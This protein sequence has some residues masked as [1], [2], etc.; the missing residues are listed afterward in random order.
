MSADSE[1][2]IKEAFQRAQKG[3]NNKAKL[4][5]SLNSRYNK[6]EDKTLFHEEFVHYLKYAMIVYKREP[7]V[8]NVIEFVVRFATSFQSPPK[9]EEEEEEKEEEE[10]EDDAEDDHPFLSFIFNF[11]LESHKANSHAVRFRVCQLINKLLGSMA[12]NA[13]IDDDLFDRIHQ[14]M[15]VRV[16]DKFPNVRIQAALAM[17]RL[18]QPKE[19]DCPTINAYMLI[20]DNDT[21]AEVRRAVLSCIAMSPRTLP[22]VLKRTRDIK[23][24]VRKLAYQVLADKVH[25]KA[26]TIAQRVGLLQQGLHDTS[27]A[28]REVVCSRMLPS[29]MLRLDGNVI[30]LL[31]R[32]DVENCAQTALDTLKAIFKGTPTEELL[33]N[34]VQL[35]NRKLIPVDSLSCENVLYWRALY[36]FIKAKGEDGDEILEQVL[37][38]AAIYADYLYGYLKTVPLLSEEQRAD[39]NQ[40]E[41]VMT[42]EFISQQ[43]IHLIGCLDT[44]E[45]GGR[46]RVFA[47]LQEMLALPQTPSSLVSLLTEKL[48]TLVPDDHRRIQTVAELISDL[49]EPINEASQPVD[50]NM[51][52][53]Q[54][55]QLAEVKVSILEAKQ[56]LEDCITTQDF[57]RAAELKDAITELENRRN[58]IIQEIAESNQP[59]DKEPRTEK[60]DPETLLRCLTMF[61][62]LLKQ[63]SLKTRIGPTI[64][65]LMS[66]LVLPSIANAHPAVRNMAVQCLGTCTLHSKELAKTHMVL[67]LQIAQLDEV[68]IRICALRAIIDQLLLFGFQLLSDP[69]ATQTVLPSQSPDRQGDGPV[70][71]KKGDVAED[72]AQSI[73]VMLS[74]FLDSE[75]SDLR[76]ETAEGLAKLMYNGRI[77]S[78]KMFSRLVLLWYNPVTE[79]DIRLR[80]CLGVFFQLYARESRVHQE[81]VEEGFLPTV[82]TLMNAPAT[83]PLAEVDINN[84]VELLVELTRPSALIK[85]S[86]NTEEVCVHDYLAVRMCGEM[87]KDP[88]APEVRLYAKTLSNLEL[89][90]DETVRKDLQV[91]LQQ[92]VQVVKDRVCLCALE[93]MIYQLVNSREQAELLSASA[94]QPLDVN[95]DELAADDPSKSAKKAKKGQRKV[96]TAKG[97]RKSSRRAESSE[98]SD[99]EN[100]P[101]SV[102]VVRPSRR[103]KTA[104]LEKT[105][106]DLNPLINQEANLS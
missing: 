84:V 18:Q 103:A 72:T 81:V 85:A 21:N 70:A 98:E 41:L 88:T 104:A 24:N 12:E 76:T 60:N 10:E 46:K 32:L 87:L 26:L 45:E 63:M 29:W 97:G 15:L 27:E 48:L 91:L 66:S 101:E 53:R 54:Q 16:T 67:L 31:H 79:D 42:K 30:E 94:L 25:I 83:S 75:V 102:P 34:R 77:S 49:R 38:D 37:P 99:G 22:K 39:F 47:V 82:R 9:T 50:E 93:K 20:L 95:A 69:A 62:E 96:C 80:H 1:I 35:D 13:Q 86:A 90:R 100:V 55:V 44:N 68:K 19:P 43:L 61:A 2:D 65:A 56:T 14:A 51:S 74:E 105:K 71:E 40:L 52:R 7:A 17:T 4:V 5:A 8:E 59:A 11:L 36:E 92:L 58:Q 73:L 23:E 57:S 33:Q 3:H 78:A 64:S 89:S 6:L 106:L 28:V